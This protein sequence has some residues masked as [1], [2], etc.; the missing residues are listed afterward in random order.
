MDRLSVGIP[1]ANVRVGSSS[2]GYNIVGTCVPSL[3][4]YMNGTEVENRTDGGFFSVYVTL[5]SGANTF[6]FTQQ[7]QANV[8]RVITRGGGTAATPT[9]TPVY[10]PPPAG[11]YISVN[12]DCGWLFPR[13]TATG[14]SQ[15]FVERGQTDRVVEVSSSGEWLR[16]LCGAWIE[17]NYIARAGQ[18]AENQLSGGAFS[19]A[20]N[21]ES[22]SWRAEK[23]PA[24]YLDYDRANGTLTAYFG[25]QSV[26][27]PVADVPADSIYASV[28]GGVTA[29]GAA[30]LVFTLGSGVVLEGY[31]FAYGDG[32]FQLRARVRKSVGSDARRPLAGFT[33]VVDAGHGGSEGGAIG[34][35]GS[36]LPEKVL[37]L[38]NARKLQER[39]EALGA[40]VVMTRTGDTTL[41]LA[42]RVLVN[43]AAMPDMFISV[44]ANSVDAT[45]NATN[46]RGFTV[47]YRNASSAPLADSMMSSLYN[48]IPNSTRNKNSNQSNLYVVRPAWAPAVI[49]EL[50]FLC[51]IEDFAWVAEEANQDKMA[52]EI[53]AAILKYYRGW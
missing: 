31:D 40:R 9:P 23:Y 30:Y 20:G 6:T 22:V 4:L 36:S 47:W 17:T 53:A 37:N 21:V 33:F 38:T 25:L 1:S 26:P 5:A 8:S 34:P 10:N 44:H 49:V 2:S 39:L 27:P 32:S 51:N 29:E 12:T 28:R 3:P 50:G 45:T 13:A 43:R 11:S 7:G 19:R 35:M 46:I 24:A 48:L 16:L 42:G 18:A 14:G 41:S 52:D 15:W